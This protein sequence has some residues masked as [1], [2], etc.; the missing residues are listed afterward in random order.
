MKKLRGRP[1]I[2]PKSQPRAV[3]VSFSSPSLCYLVTQD[4][5]QKVP[6]RLVLGQDGVA[7]G[8]TGPSLFSVLNVCFFSPLIIAWGV[9]LGG[10]PHPIPVLLRSQE[11]TVV[12]LDPSGAEQCPEEEM[13]RTQM[14]MEPGS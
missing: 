13:V 5:L 4:W 3:Q 1:E 8:T 12:S 7:S 14:T 10:S 6:S 9:R 11:R 2:C